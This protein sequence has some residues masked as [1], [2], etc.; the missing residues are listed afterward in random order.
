MQRNP[1]EE[2]TKPIETN[3]GMTEMGELVDRY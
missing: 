2:K 3:P 1:Y